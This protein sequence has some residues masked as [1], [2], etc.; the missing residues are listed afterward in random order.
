MKIRTFI[1]SLAAALLAVGLGG[2]E[3]RAGSTTMTLDSLLGKSVSFDGLTFT[4]DSYT[5]SS[6]SLPTASEVNVIWPTL[7]GGVGLTFQAGWVAPPGTSANASIVYT[8]SAPAKIS[9]AF[10]SGLPEVLNGTGS[11]S[12]TEKLSWD[13]TSR[14]LRISDPPGNLPDHVTFPAQ[15]LITVQKSISLNGGTGFASVSII[16]QTFSVVPEP[17]SAALLGIGLCGLLTVPGLRKRY[18]LP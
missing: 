6:A 17:T 4:F 9:D 8:V 15:S 12:V 14:S 11:A 10:L 13:Q 16:N 2:I 1:L 7:I 5:A 3:A 18:L